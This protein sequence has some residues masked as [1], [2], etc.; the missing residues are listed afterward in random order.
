LQADRK[1]ANALLARIKQI[2]IADARYSRLPA[3]DLNVNFD[4]SWPAWLV[5]AEG[6]AT[7]ML[8]TLPSLI[9]APRLA[10]ETG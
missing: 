5:S 1:Y 9:V 3:A 8:T 2:R 7:A 4:R 10:T 6:C